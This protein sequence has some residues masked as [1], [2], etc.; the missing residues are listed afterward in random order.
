ML[1]RDSGQDD[2]R[3]EWRPQP[4]Q[5]VHLG[6]VPR[7]LRG[8]CAVFVGSN[9]AHLPEVVFPVAA[10]ETDV[11]PACSTWRPFHAQV[12]SDLAWSLVVK[13][14]I[15]ETLKHTEGKAVGDHR[16]DSTKNVHTDLRIVLRVP[17]KC[18]CTVARALEHWI[19][20]S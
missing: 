11:C 6:R 10:S 19:L 16:L 14:M 1:L 20:V 8:S 7:L 5:R 4:D 3:S 15:R 13:A 18:C 2:R 17:G 9:R 12:E